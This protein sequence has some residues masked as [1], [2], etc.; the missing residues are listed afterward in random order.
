MITS[1]AISLKKFNKFWVKNKAILDW[2]DPTA[3]AS[4]PNLVSVIHDMSNFFVASGWKGLFIR[5]STRS[6]KDAALSRLSIVEQLRKEYDALKL[7]E[8]GTT[9]SAT[10]TLLHALYRVSTYIL[11]SNNPGEAIQLLVESKR[12]QDDLDVYSKSAS[13]G[14]FNFVLREFAAFEPEN[15]FRAFIF[16]QKLT[17]ITQYNGMFDFICCSPLFRSSIYNPKAVV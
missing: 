9:A 10:S 1:R 8:E 13:P 17:A 12:I 11:K 14:T 2:D 16:K 5:L 7:L 15:E 4:F 6:P 3:Q